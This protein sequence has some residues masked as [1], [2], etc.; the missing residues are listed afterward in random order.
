MRAATTATR[1]RPG[2]VAKK[3]VGAAVPFE[4]ARPVPFVPLCP[5]FD[6]TALTLSSVPGEPAE[7][8]L[9]SVTVTET[10]KTPTTPGEQEKL[11]DVFWQGGGSPTHANVGVPAP[12]AT[13]A[14]IVTAWPTSVFFGATVGAPTAGSVSTGIGAEAAGEVAT[15][16]ESF[17]V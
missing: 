15:P 17:Q 8:P 11:W 5:P 14:L 16:L 2:V 13:A 4:V 3:E 7:T 9:R 10:L 12:P 6:G 1:A